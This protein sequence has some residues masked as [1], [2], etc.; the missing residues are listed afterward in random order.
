MVRFRLQLL[1]MTR[2]H[3]RGNPLTLI[4]SNWL[5]RLTQKDVTFEVEDVV[6]ICKD[7]NINYEN[8]ELTLMEER[9]IPV[10]MKIYVEHLRLRA[11]SVSDTSLVVKLPK[12]TTHNYDYMLLPAV[13]TQLVEVK[14]N[15]VA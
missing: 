13:L 5:E 4:S 8:R 12:S 14:K 3:S 6:G 7:F 1:Q 15:E 2:F 10:A 9:N 11:A